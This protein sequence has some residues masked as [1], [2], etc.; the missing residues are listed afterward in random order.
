MTAT[1]LFDIGHPAHV[2]LFK[3]A[4][5][6]LKRNGHE[7]RVLSRDKD[8][9]VTLLDRYDIDHTPLS[10]KGT[11]ALSL[12]LEWIEREF[13]PS[14]RLA[15][16][17]PTSSS[18]FRA[19]AAHAARLLGVPMVVFDDSE[20]ATLQARLTYPFATT[21]CTPEGFER[22]VG[23]KQ[24]RYPGYHELAY[25]HPD[26]FD[27]D[28]DRLEAVGVDPREPYA[29]C[30]FVSW[31]ASH[32]VGNRGLSPTPSANSCRCWPTTGRCT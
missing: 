14:V 24:D 8:L 19:P 7:T 15:A 23:D 16:A 11:N 29:V 26:R 28:P 18:A 1:V 31:G 3:H 30:R 2:H 12:Y 13:G 17:I 10:T 22:D 25:L 4:I 27:P 9:T 20:R 5:R 6:E 21:I 32:D